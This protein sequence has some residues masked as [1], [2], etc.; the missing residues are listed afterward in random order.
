MVVAAILTVEDQGKIKALHIIVELAVKL[1]GLGLSVAILKLCAEKRPLDEK[2][3]IFYSGL[4]LIPIASV[5]VYGAICLLGSFGLISQDPT[6]NSTFKYYGVI[7]IPMTLNFYMIAYFQAFKEFKLISKVQS[8]SRL[9]SF[10]LILGFT[11]YFLF[12][13]Y[14]IASIVGFSSTTF[15]FAY[16][17][18]FSRVR[19]SLFKSFVRIRKEVIAIAKF[20]M[21]SQFFNRFNAFVGLLILNF[22]I[23]DRVE[24]GY[25]AFCITILEGLSIAVR[26]I[27]QITIPYFSEKSGDIVIWKKSF[28]KYNRILFFTILFIVLVSILVLPFLIN[29]VFDNK[30][31]G[32]IVY[33]LYLIPSWGVRSLVSLRGSGLIGLGKVNVNFYNNVLISL[34][35]TPLIYVLAEM[36]G[37]WGAVYGHIFTSIFTYVII[38]WTFRRIMKKLSEEDIL[39]RANVE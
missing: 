27:Q 20:A 13:G 36:Y 14:I 10:L 33:L 25:F 24:F 5:V 9:F 17:L 7:L 11:Y 12:N 1:S 30:Y 35:A 28:Y 34:I 38:A 8:I 15:Y 29:F 19:K 32:S 39:N 3:E 31:D 37:V 2:H 23:T 21:I 18:D 26:S 6:I 4:R 16:H 22:I